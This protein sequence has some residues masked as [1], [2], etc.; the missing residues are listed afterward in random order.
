MTTAE[1]KHK[2]WLKTFLLVSWLAV[3]VVGFMVKLPRTFRHYDKELHAAFYFLAAGFLNVLF[4]NGK[5]VRHIIIFILLYLFSVSIEFA[6]EYSN[7]LLHKQI[8]GRFDPEDIKYNLRGLIA[9]SVL[10]VPYWIALKV[11]NKLSYKEVMDRK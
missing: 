3:S 5:F 4:A 9:F 11:Y 1:T 10:W 6:Q 8:H 2:G 7:K